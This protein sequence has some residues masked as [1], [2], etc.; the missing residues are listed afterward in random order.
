MSI[1]IFFSRLKSIIIKSRKYYFLK[2]IIKSY[3]SSSPFSTYHDRYGRFFFFNETWYL[4]KSFLILF[5]SWKGSDTY[6]QLKKEIAI[7]RQQSI[8]LMNYEAEDSNFVEKDNFGTSRQLLI[9][10]LDLTKYLVTRDSTVLRFL[11]PDTVLIFF[12]FARQACTYP[13]EWQPYWPFSFKEM[14]HIFH[15]SPLPCHFN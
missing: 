13:F 3:H 7:G 1:T 5:T 8:P 2:N 6:N 12:S 15:I 10:L 14:K 4:K 11:K 9:S